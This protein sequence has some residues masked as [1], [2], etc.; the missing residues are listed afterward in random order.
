MTASSIAS[1]AAATRGW[2]QR[3]WGG[4]EC[5]GR[6]SLRLLPL[7]VEPPV[8]RTAPPPRTKPNG[9]LAW[10]LVCRVPEAE[11]AGVNDMTTHWGSGVSRVR[12]SSASGVRI[13]GFG[14][15]RVTGVS[16]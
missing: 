15:V 12:V 14:R 4:R 5:W 13:S 3:R 2:S 10:E 11:P 16:W 1:A 7:E 8:G 6:D 9:S